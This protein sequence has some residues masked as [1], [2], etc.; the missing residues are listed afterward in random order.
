M[1][2]ALHENSRRVN[3][4][5]SSSPGATI[6]SASA[7]VTLPHRRYRVEVARRLAIDEIAHVSAFHAFTSARSTVSARSRM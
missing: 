7:T 5:G 4:V 2:Q 6:I 1:H 3:L